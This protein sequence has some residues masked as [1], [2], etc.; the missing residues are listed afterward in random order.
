MAATTWEPSGNDALAVQLLKTNTW[1]CYCGPSLWNFS[2]DRLKDTMHELLLELPK[3]GRHRLRLLLRP[4]NLLGCLRGRAEQAFFCVATKRAERSH[5]AGVVLNDEKHV[6]VFLSGPSELR[7]QLAVWL[8]A[9]FKTS[10]HRLELAP[11]ELSMTAGLGVSLLNLGQN[12]QEYCLEV[13][14]G[15]M[16]L[17]FSE[18]VVEQLAP[19]ALLTENGSRALLLALCRHAHRH[20]LPVPYEEM[21]LHSVNLPSLFSVNHEGT[22][23]VHASAPIPQLVKCLSNAAEHTLFGILP[24]VFEEEDTESMQ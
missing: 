22:V 19:P 15:D 18:E 2:A 12:T 20:V 9:E 6:L 11:W 10:L 16:K 13:G 5:A 3:S 7:I 4:C 14:M 1:S 17:R 24:L 23:E 21:P 8:G